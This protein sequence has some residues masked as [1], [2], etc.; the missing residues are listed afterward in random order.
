MVGRCAMRSV[1][2]DDRAEP[3][4]AEVLPFGRRRSVA[5]RF[6]YDIAVSFAGAQRSYVYET[7]RAARDLG[8]RV[9]YDEDTSGDWWGRNFLV[10]Q[11]RV[12]LNGTRFVVPFLSEEYLASP[13]GMDEL[14]FA[15]ITA[16]RKPGPYILPVVFG[17]LD[18]PAEVLHAFTVH[19]D[20]CK[21]TPNQLA[22]HMR[23]VVTGS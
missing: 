14:R 23:R 6:D 13:F 4:V 18:L 15:T 19:L 2:N 7:V 20:A 8:L 16:V 5:E 21:H 3:V 11:R 17:D 22:A 9:F 10:E 12:Y 1:G